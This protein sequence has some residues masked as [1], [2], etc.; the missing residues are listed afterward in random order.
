MDWDAWLAEQ[1]QQ[2]Q[3]DLLT[4]QRLPITGPQ[5]ERI[6]VCGSSFLNFC[7]NDYLGLAADPALQQTIRD[8]LE[9]L[10]VGS[11]ASH[12]VCGHMQ[13]HDELEQALAQ[14]VG[15]ERALLFSGGYMANLGIPPALTGRSDLILSDRLNHASLID[16]IRLSRAHHKRYRHADPEH[17]RQILKNEDYD[18]C[19]IVTDGVFSMDGDIAPLAELA[20]LAADH[21]GLLMVD[22]AHG[23]GCTGPAGRGSLAH[24]S[25]EEFDR[26]LLIGT[27]GKAFGTFG[28]FAA[29]SNA[30][31]EQL[32][33][34]A[35]TYIY[36][37]AIPPVLAKAT[38][39]SLEA[40]QSGSRL[41]KLQD[42][43]QYFRTE[44]AQRGIPL[45][46]SGSPIQPLILGDNQTVLNA[47]QTL[48]NNGIR[49]GAIRPP[50]VPEGTAR[51]RITISAAHKTEHIRQLIHA[52]TQV[53]GVEQ[54]S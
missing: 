1:H 49:V 11:G 53:A 8:S 50:T 34:R 13:V 14:F 10:G 33:Q 47:A 51:L 45:G 16:G 7:S 25:I 2:R 36:T 23:L 4:R 29:G 27:L 43:I 17:A 18:R 38:L 26:I 5:Q 46:E 20:A 15:A 24:H 52:L 6:D 40:V 21:N 37:T 22:D 41:Q 32:L 39:A 54:T 9:S 19:M 48:E 42:N 31:I 28:A 44:C 30:L 12:M 35:R 3:Q